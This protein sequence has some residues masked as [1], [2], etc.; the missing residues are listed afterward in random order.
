MPTK[1][2]LEERVAELEDRLEEDG[3][4][5]EKD[6]TRPKLA[7]DEYPCTSCGHTPLDEITSANPA[8]QT[9]FN[10]PKCGLYHEVHNSRFE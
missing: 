8:Q 3:T 10:C 9:A 7:K 1:A 4:V 6:A 5:T 2:E